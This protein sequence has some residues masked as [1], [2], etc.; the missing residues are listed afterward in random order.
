MLETSSFNIGNSEFLALK[1]IPVKIGAFCMKKRPCF[2]YDFLN[3][4]YYFYLFSLSQFHFSI[5]YQNS[6]LD[7]GKEN[8]RLRER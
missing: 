1:L 7:F 8:Y 6:I 5:P 3:N 4:R 2:L